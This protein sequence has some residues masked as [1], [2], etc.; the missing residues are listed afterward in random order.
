MTKV[1]IE[2]DYLGVNRVMGTSS[3][4]QLIVFQKQMAKIQT[5]Y[6]C[7]IPEAK[8]HGWS[9]IICTPAQLILKRV[10]TDQVTT[11][12]G[13]GLYNGNTNSLKLAYKQKVNPYEEYKE[14]K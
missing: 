1:E 7:N 6:K 13:P 2:Y 9:W 10:I 14:H 5:S 8:D 4:G 11:P 12:T 3:T